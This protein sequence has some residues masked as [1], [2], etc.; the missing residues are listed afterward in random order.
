MPLILQSMRQIDEIFS[1][2]KPFLIAG[3]CSAESETQLHQVATALKDSGISA[4]RA[5]VWKPRTRPNAY[6]GAGMQALKW[7]ADIQEQYTFPVVTEVANARHVEACL[8]SGFKMVWLGART[9]VNPFSVQ[10]IADALR[11][12]PTTVLIKNPVNPDLS[13]WLGAF[14]RLDKA[15]IINLLAVHRGFSS[16][17]RTAYRN[18]PMWD[19]AIALRRHLPGLPILCDPSHISGN[20]KHIAD[21]SQKALDLNYDGL[22]IEVHPQPE[23]ALSDSEQQLSPEAFLR[24]VG[25]LQVRQ[26]STGDPV[27]RETLET[28]RASIDALDAQTI[29]LLGK[30]MELVREIGAYKRDHDITIFQLDRWLQILK[31]RGDAAKDAGIDEAFIERILN[32]IHNESI[33][34]QNEIVNQQPASN[35]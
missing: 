25:A 4:F 19:I 13:L 20:R 12:T 33:R 26:A 1:G 15:G 11:G 30:R 6:E 14:E 29:E 24:M 34:L 23:N 2:Q 16:Y 5:G 21:I 28:L 10:E 17:E 22:M 35:G 31:T 27:V 8:Q 18:R 3:P 32:L 9:V 7:L